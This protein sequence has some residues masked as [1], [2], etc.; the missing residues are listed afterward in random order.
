[1]KAK[2][3]RGSISWIWWNVPRILAFKKWDEEFKARLGYVMSQLKLLETLSQ[4]KK[5]GGEKKERKKPC[6]FFGN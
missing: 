4:K 5:G 6:E 2:E 3:R 1:M